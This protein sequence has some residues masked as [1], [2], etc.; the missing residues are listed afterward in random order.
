MKIT[1]D[2]ET[3][4]NSALVDALPE[5]KVAI[6]NLKDPAKIQEKIKEAKEEQISKMAL[7]PLYGRV[8]AY[9]AMNEEDITFRDCI[10]EDSDAAE[11]ELLDRLFSIIAMALT[12]EQ[13]S[14]TKGKIITYNGNGFDL[15]FIYRRAIVLGIDP[16]AD[17]CLPSLANLTARYNNH[18]HMD[19]MT[20]W[21]GFGNY[22]KLDNISRILFNDTKIQID[23]KT[24]PD[25][26]TTE[27]GRINLLNYCE[28]DVRLT[29]KLYYRIAGIL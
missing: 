14:D 7:N 26:I 18:N 28:Q 4:P 20:A 25:L 19:L 12:P 2:I 23:V 13:D 21:C 1:F 3:I 10:T 17:Y 24:F 16:V 22:E 29:Q 9:V 15:P 27:A 6:G 5:P 11:T 8:C